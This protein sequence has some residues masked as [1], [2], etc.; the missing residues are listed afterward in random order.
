MKF[1]LNARFYWKN[2]KQGDETLGKTDQKLGNYPPRQET[3]APAG[4]RAVDNHAKR[5]VKRAF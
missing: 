1:F 4:D 2:T 3:R 5:L